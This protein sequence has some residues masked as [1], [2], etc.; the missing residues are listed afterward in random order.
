M[1]LRMSLRNGQKKKGIMVSN[2]KVL[3]ETEKITSIL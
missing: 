2:L 3:E 1:S